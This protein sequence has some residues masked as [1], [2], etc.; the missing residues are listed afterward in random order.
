MKIAYFD[1]IAGISGDMTLGA[2]VSAGV[3]IDELRFELSKLNLKGV[4]LEAR[5]IQRNGITA[6]KL[7]VIISSAHEHHRGIS[8]VFKIIETSSL[9]DRVKRDAKKIFMEIAQAESKIHSTSLEKIHF[10]EVGMLDSIVDIVGTAICLDKLGIDKV[11]SSPV[12]I[13][14]SGFIQAEHGILP[15]PAPATTEILKNYPVMLTDIPFELTTPT[16]A[17]IIKAMSSGI[18]S[19]EE[20]KIKS[21]GYGAGTRELSQVP[22]LLRI[23][24]G[25]LVPKYDEDEVVIVETNI[26]DMNPEIFPYVIERL[27]E[28]GGLDAY[29]IPIIMKKGRSGILLSVLVSRSKL[30]TI[31]QVVFSQTTTIGVRI[32]PA[33]RRKLSR[34]QEEIQ[35]QFGKVT[36]KVVI[37]NGIRR[38][39][40]EFEECNRIAKE[41]GL[42]LIQVYKILELEFSNYRK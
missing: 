27:L 11:Y 8:D 34:S 9:S 16:G 24:V 23:I 14:S 31:L 19:F 38:I 10:H 20:I 28:S 17:A 35:T 18:L 15:V 26:D 6:V 42:P 37:N 41:K 12:K 40:P 4:E 13:G 1:T 39:V 33:E 3:S 21:V 36:A 5:H 30:D 7:D 29:I 25:E 2:F 32:Q 22:N